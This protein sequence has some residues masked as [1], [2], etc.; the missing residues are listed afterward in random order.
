MHNR[1][2]FDI[3]KQVENFFSITYVTLQQPEIRVLFAQP[4]SVPSC[5]AIRSKKIC[6]HVVV[7]SPNRPAVLAEKFYHLA[8]NE[9]AGAG[10]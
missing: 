3:T 5:V 10:N 8:A 9:P 2:R 6:A 1:G 7:D 4:I